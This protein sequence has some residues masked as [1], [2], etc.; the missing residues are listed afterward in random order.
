MRPRGASI[1]PAN[2]GRWTRRWRAP[3]ARRASRGAA[4]RAALL[5]RRLDLLEQSLEYRVVVAAFELE[6][7]R[8]P[9]AVAKRRQ[10]H[11]LH[12]VGSHVV[13]AFEQRRAARRAH[14]R[15]AAA[16]PGAGDDARPGARCP[17]DPEGGVEASRVPAQARGQ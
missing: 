13:A 7:G 1:A 2:P 8:W 17:H 4:C 9:D 12:V 14:E 16:W 3:R 6:L 10:R 15:D 11:F 5:A